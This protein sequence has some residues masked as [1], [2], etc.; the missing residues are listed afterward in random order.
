M[1][2]DDL[3]A[4][5]GVMDKI[6][7]GFF[8]D[9]GGPILKSV[10]GADSELDSTKAC[11]EVGDI[12][13]TYAQTLGEGVSEHSRNLSAAA[14]HYER[15]DI[16]A[17]EAIDFDPA[18]ERELE[19]GDDPGEPGYDPIIEY[20]DA[21]H[22]AGLLDGPSSGMYREWLQNAAD[23][24]VPPETIVEIARQQNITPSSF[25][26]LKGLERVTNKNDETNPK[27]DTDF[28]MLPQNVTA[29]Q[30]RQ[31]ALMTYIFNAGTGYG[32]SE[33]NANNDFAETPYSAAEVQRI[34]DRQ[35]ANSWSYD[36]LER[37]T[38][39]FAATPNGMVMGVGGGPIQQLISQQGGTC[40]GDVFAVNI[41][42]PIDGG[43]AQLRDIIR[44]GTMQS[45]ADH[46]G[47]LAKGNDLDRV[48]H[49]E[50][51]HSQQW[52]DKGFAKFLQEYFTPT[53]ADPNPFE[54][55]A[56]GSD[57]GYH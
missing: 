7:S 20:E 31:A 33:G 30:A 26:V 29:E 51:R 50:E 25:D 27:D 24:D 28:F 5:S 53:E 54:T 18:E 52:A 3:R 4:A 47:I 36:L 32:S 11:G 6:A 21:L 12:F 9:G 42:N 8:N 38:G 19:V 49:H 13:Q 55:N 43:A 41:D 39:T 44:S 35:T 56:G 10:T 46:D 15:G 2:V 57:G 48:L 1:I 16:A 40:V 45:D 37:A 34:K 23:N 17:A 14:G 22:D